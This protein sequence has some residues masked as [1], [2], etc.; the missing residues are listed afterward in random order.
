MEELPRYAL[1]TDPEIVRQQIEDGYY[2]FGNL[3]N[4]IDEP[5]IL[6]DPMCKDF[7]IVGM[8]RGFCSLTGHSLEDAKGKN[9]R[10]MFEGVPE[11][12]ISRSSRKNVANFCNMCRVE[13]ID[14][15]SDCSSVQPNARRDGSH[16]VN[17]FLLGLVKAEGRHFILGVQRKLNEGLLPTMRLNEV[18]DQAEALRDIL[19]GIKQRLAAGPLGQAR[20]HSMSCPPPSSGCGPAPAFAFYATRLQD[21]CMI[22]NQGQTAVRREPQELAFNCLNFGDRPVEFGPDGLSFTLR[23]DGVTN[24][25]KGLPVLGYTKRQ[26]TDS[27]DLFP[28]VARCLGSSVLVGADGEAFARDQHGHFKMGFKKPPQD[29][30]QRWSQE[31]DGKRPDTPILQRG[32]LLRCNYS[33][34]GQIQLWLNSEVIVEFDTGR[35][36]DTESDYYAVVDVCLSASSMTI[37]G[38]TGCPGR[39]RA[40]V[41]PGMAPTKNTASKAEAL[42][43]RALSGTWG[44]AGDFVTIAL[45]LSSIVLAGTMLFGPG[46]RHRL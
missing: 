10:M 6:V 33:N 29:Q 15:L 32:D 12:H 7:P 26:P 11:V 28:C 19:K 21:H 23:V 2:G 45:G 5:A 43:S 17:L 16:F 39:P 37:V 25:F 46:K 38:P 36:L 31:V 42:V 18:E 22:M 41:E 13:G 4:D 27:R 24:S 40:Q 34:A 35:P 3:L 20:M 1:C 30:V 14:D 8:S 9:C 44:S